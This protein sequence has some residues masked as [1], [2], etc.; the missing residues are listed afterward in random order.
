MGPPPWKEVV[1]NQRKGQV[2]Q[3]TARLGAELASLLHQRMSHSADRPQPTTKQAEWV[4]SCGRFNF[5]SRSACRACGAPWQ[6][7]CRL[8]PAGTP[9]QKKRGPSPEPGTSNGAGT[10]KDGSTKAVAS[11]EGTLEAAESALAAARAAQL[12][13]E[14]IQ[15]LQAQVNAR[16]ESQQAPKPLAQ[17]F[18]EATRREKVAQGAKARAEAEATKAQERLTKATQELEEAKAE[19]ARV[20]K[21]VV[22]PPPNTHANALSA[23]LEAVKGAGENGDEGKS[24]LE[25]AAAAAA[26]VLKEAPA[27]PSMH[28]TEPLESSQDTVMRSQEPDDAEVD[29]LIRD[30]SEAEEPEAKR[31]RLREIWGGRRSSPPR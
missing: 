8:V 31:A 19:L 27:T 23:L 26:E 16:K 12:P 18:S 15:Q 21:E 22:P 4:C 3:E 7:S 6:S 1:R 17:R 13:D 29:R 9:H 28:Q 20:Q 5:V 10:S 14:I 24:K 2:T 25:Q 30:I 11:V